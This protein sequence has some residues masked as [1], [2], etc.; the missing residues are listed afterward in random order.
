MPP[1]SRI[2]ALGFV[3]SL[4]LLFLGSAPRSPMPAPAG[5]ETPHRT[6]AAGRAPRVSGHLVIQNYYYAK[7]GLEE[8]VYRL[9]LRASRVRADLGLV[10]GRVLRR[11]SGPGSLPTVIWEAEYPDSLARARDVA[12]LS[13]SEEFDR[14]AEEMGTLLRRFERA[15]WWVDTEVSAR[16]SASSGR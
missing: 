15:S 9:R 10:R 14:I 8:S 2:P 11:V 12:E 4:P 7:P 16:P 6:G 1:R 5:H 3:L 13:G